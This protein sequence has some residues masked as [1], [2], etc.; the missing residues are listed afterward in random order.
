MFRRVSLVLW[1]MS[2]CGIAAAAG[3]LFVSSEGNNAIKRFDGLTGAYVGDFVAANSGGLTKPE[4]IRFG[5]DGNLYVSSSS[6]NEVLR[7]NGS[8]GAFM[9]G[10]ASGGGCNRPGRLS[11][12]P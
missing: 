9:G 6:T 1:A 8:T 3:D 7:Y 11:L 2:A 4:G 10:F 5:A 12:R